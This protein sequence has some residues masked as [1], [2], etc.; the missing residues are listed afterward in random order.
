M[1]QLPATISIFFRDEVLR[2]RRV[3]AQAQ[4]IEVPKTIS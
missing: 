4:I 1:K 2:Q 3:A